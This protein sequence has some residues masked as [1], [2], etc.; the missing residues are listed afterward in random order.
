MITSHHKLNRRLTFLQ[1]EVT[2]VGLD[3]K[4]VYSEKATVWAYLSPPKTKRKYNDGVISYV[5]GYNITIRY[6]QRFDVNTNLKIVVDKGTNREEE[7]K[8]S[9]WVNRD[10]K[11]NWID[12]VGFK[13]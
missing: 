7:L 9:K 6:R 4:T 2:G 10:D 3:Q 12:I 13:I 5:S 8:L 1:G 11:N